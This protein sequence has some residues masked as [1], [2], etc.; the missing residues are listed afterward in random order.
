MNNRPFVLL[1]CLLLVGMFS[2]QYSYGQYTLI[3][4]GT[5]TYIEEIEKYGDVIVVNGNYQYTV[6]CFNDCD[7]LISILPPN[8]NFETS[9]GLVVLDTNLFY[10]SNYNPGVPGMST[11]LL[12]TSN[13]GQTWE[14]F[15][16]EYGYI[17]HNLLVFDTSN[18]TLALEDSITKFT[19]NSGV[20][21]QQGS[22]HGVTNFYA[23]KTINDSTGIICGVDKGAITTNKG[24][25]WQN[26]NYIP[27]QTTNIFAVTQD[28]IYF[29]SR[30]Y[31]PTGY[32]SYFYNFDTASRIDINLPHFEPWGLYVVNRNEIYLVGRGLPEQIGR[33]MKTT[34]QGLTWSYI[35]V[36]ES[37]YLLDIELINDSIFLIC[38]S[39]G[40]LLKWNK[41]APM[42]HDLSVNENDFNLSYLSI[43]P[44]PSMSVQ[45]LH[46]QTSITENT[47]IK[48]I[49]FTGKV[50]QE[51]YS[52]I[53]DTN[54]IALNADIS[55]LKTG[56]YFYQVKIGSKSEFVRFVKQ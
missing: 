11:N 52:G 41:N 43:F 9:L 18:I 26:F 34:D 27:A 44:N 32:L 1:L 40:I 37:N 39:S 7:T 2:S 48:I 24:A 13:G 45:T 6:K 14:S 25:T 5:T 50:I 49:D 4:T 22:N 53:P 20:T 46:L 21:W 47:S 36:P 3:P 23:S 10:V 28:S 35:N 16:F 29:V 33:I 56:I 19:S 30:S 42:L 51:I 38:G 55:L 15:F 54:E 8:S 31:P 17:A 12:R